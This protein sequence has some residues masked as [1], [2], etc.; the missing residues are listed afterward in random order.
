M[1]KCH[2][3]IGKGVYVISILLQCYFEGF[4]NVSSSSTIIIDLDDDDEEEQ[5]LVN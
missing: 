4:T 1:L 3:W 2:K 5:K